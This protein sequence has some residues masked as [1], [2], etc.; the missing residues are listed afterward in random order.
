M[1]HGIKEKLRGESV[2]IQDAVSRYR[3]PLI[4]FLNRYVRNVSVAEEL[5][6][7]AFVSLLLHP[8]RAE[9]MAS[10]KTY[11]FTIGRNKALNYLKKQARRQEIPLDEAENLAEESVLEER[12]LQQE[13]A[14]QVNA[15]LKTL[16]DEYR[17]VLHLLY[18]E[19]LSMQEAGAVMR[20]NA[21]QMENLAYRARKAMKKALEKEGFR[22]EE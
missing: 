16:R 22:N 14:K 10:L 21:K 20:K 2:E 6:E 8:Y 3:E 7:D 9:K 18:F 15:V 1:E 12:L 11:L 5:A 17:E 4:F 19:E 13:R